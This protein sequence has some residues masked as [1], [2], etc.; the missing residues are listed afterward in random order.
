LSQQKIIILQQ[1]IKDYN[2]LDK[3]DIEVK[4]HTLDSIIQIESD[5]DISKQLLYKH[6]KQWFILYIKSIESKN[7][8]YDEILYEKVIEKINYL[9]ITEKISILNYFIRILKRYYHEEKISQYQ[10]LIK[11][12]ELKCL[13]DNNSYFNYLLKLSTSNLLSMLITLFIML[14]LFSLFWYLLQEYTSLMN[15]CLLEF[16]SNNY[17]NYFLNMSSYIFGITS[18]LKLYNIFELI[19]FIT[20]KFVFYIYLTYFV[21]KEISNK[22]DKK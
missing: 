12:L 16:T 5:L 10:K 21:I 8:S 20:V 19:L 13:L 9:S 2:K 11:E 3:N 17:M 22:M 1:W 6:I 4:F 15:I 7:F 14:L 18:K